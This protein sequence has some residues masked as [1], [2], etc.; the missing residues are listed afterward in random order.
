MGRER[1]LSW[2]LPW[3][4]PVPSADRLLRRLERNPGYN[5]ARI[6]S[7]ASTRLHASRLVLAEQAISRAEASGRLTFATAAERTAE[8]A[9][10]EAAIEHSAARLARNRNRV[11][12]YLAAGVTADAAGLVPPITVKGVSLN[13][14]SEVR[15]YIMDHWWP[16]INRGGGAA[17]VNSGAWG[18]YMQMMHG[19]PVD[20]GNAVSV[21]A[22]LGGT[23]LADLR[24][25]PDADVEGRRLSR[26]ADYISHP[27]VDR[28]SHTSDL[29]AAGTRY[30]ATRGHI[31]A[32]LGSGSGMPRR[33]AVDLRQ[34]G[35]GGL[36][37]E[38]I[39]IS[40][41]T[42]TGPVEVSSVD[43]SFAEQGIFMMDDRANATGV[44]VQVRVR[45]GDGSFRYQTVFNGRLDPGRGNLF[46]AQER[47]LRAR[48][49]LQP[50]GLSAPTLT[51]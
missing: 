50:P 23:L 26:L 8:V 34:F 2:I 25:V 15:T 48:A 47:A 27:R 38:D 32:T 7:A 46:E 14:G 35:L 17:L 36:G 5:P 11:L 41:L 6:A 4:E 28:V 31:I 12:R 30:A 18:P 44:R 10:L 29:G 51:G 1:F 37:R 9:R 49:D 39:R 13:I 33:L 45:Q 16:H 20:H 43:R 24:R 40:Y 21:S 22:S 3:R 42:P 19:T